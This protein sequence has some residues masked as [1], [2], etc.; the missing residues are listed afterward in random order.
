MPRLMLLRHAKAE[1]PAG[2]ADFDRPLA[3][4]GRHDSLAVGRH[5]AE[6]GWLPEAALC[7]PARRTRET[8]AA[9]LP[10]LPAAVDATWPPDLYAADG[11]DILALLRAAG[12]GPRSL[13]VVGHNPAMHDAALSLLGG[14]SGEAAAELHRKFPTAAL[15]VFDCAG[16]W[17]DLA[18][19]RA[20]LRGFVR[21]RDL[22]NR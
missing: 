4:R 8:L 12:G 1:R 14:T 22:S 13:L 18:A 20:V 7:S 6:L 17:A 9:L 3:E 11:D 5:M 16:E 19:G 2:V 15:A 21:P 10:A